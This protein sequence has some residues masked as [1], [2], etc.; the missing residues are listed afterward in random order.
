MLESSSI[1]VPGNQLDHSVSVLDDKNL[2]KEYKQCK[3]NLRKTNGNYQQL[4]KEHAE[5]QHNYSLKD[6]QV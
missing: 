5:L 4:I 2:K 3:K 1:I 6:N